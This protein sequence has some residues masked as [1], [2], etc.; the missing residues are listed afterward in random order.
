MASTCSTSWPPRPT[1]RQDTIISHRRCITITFVVGS[2]AWHGFCW[3]K[4]L[5]FMEVGMWEKKIYIE[6]IYGFLLGNWGIPILRSNQLQFGFPLHKDLVK[7][8]SVSN[9]SFC[10]LAMAQNILLP[11]A[12]WLG[13]MIHKKICGPKN[14]CT[15]EFWSHGYIVYN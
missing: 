9:D 11:M 3:R 15:Y 2:W 4:N 12:G 13:N 7:V 10:Y 1:N 8:A 6:T 5:G 14:Q